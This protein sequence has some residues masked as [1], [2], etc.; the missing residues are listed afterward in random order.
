MDA[1]RAQL[2]DVP[3]DSPEP[4]FPFGFGLSY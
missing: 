4:S 1:V 3:L 2:E